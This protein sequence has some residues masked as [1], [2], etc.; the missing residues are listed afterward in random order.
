MD[1]MG[2]PWKNIMEN[3]P[4]NCESGP[5]IFWFPLFTIGTIGAIGAS[6]IPRAGTWT[7]KHQGCTYLLRWYCLKVQDKGATNTDNPIFILILITIIESMRGN[8]IPPSTIVGLGWFGMVWS[9]KWA[10]R[11]YCMAAE[12]CNFCSLLRPEASDKPKSLL[13]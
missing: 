7:A 8:T 1:G 2:K 13:G 12:S 5:N 4:K 6:R 9:A 10:H 3:L 11:L